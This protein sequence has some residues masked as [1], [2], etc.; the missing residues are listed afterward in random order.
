M[1]NASF[2]RILYPALF[3]RKSAEEG[4]YSCFCICPHL[5]VSHFTG[6]QLHLSTFTF[7]LGTCTQGSLSSVN[8]HK[9]PQKQHKPAACVTYE[10]YKT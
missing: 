7:H 6:F 1:E 5:T 9:T 4:R 3:L 10:E 2:C 8:T